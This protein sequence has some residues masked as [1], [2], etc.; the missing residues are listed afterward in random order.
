MTNAE[1]TTHFC[2][3][4]VVDGKNARENAGLR[5]APAEVRRVPL[6]GSV[7]ALC[8]TRVD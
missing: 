6:A 4:L 5:T 7:G 8:F 2:E 1:R 3:R